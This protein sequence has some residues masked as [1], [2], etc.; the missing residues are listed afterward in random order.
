M[1]AFGHFQVLGADKVVGPVILDLRLQRDDRRAAELVMLIQWRAKQRMIQRCSF[2][3]GLSSTFAT[4]PL[5]QGDLF[6]DEPLARVIPAALLEVTLRQGATA[7]VI[8]KLA[9]GVRH[10]FAACLIVAK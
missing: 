1:G 10:D 7:I 6:G 2:C 5:R 9:V 8:T 4:V 3:Q